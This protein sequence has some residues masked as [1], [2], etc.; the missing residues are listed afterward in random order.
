MKITAAHVKDNKV[1]FQFFKDGEFWYR[2][3]YSDNTGIKDFD[4][5]VPMSDTIGTT[6]FREDKAIL[7]MRWMNAWIKATEKPTA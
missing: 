7:F 1:R 5:P 6:L 3:T 4:F 2:L